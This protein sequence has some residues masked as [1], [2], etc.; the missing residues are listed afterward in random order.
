M[1]RSAIGASRNVGHNAVRHQIPGE[2]PAA[3]RRRL[4]EDASLDCVNLAVL[5]LD[6][7]RGDKV[8]RFDVGEA[9]LDKGDDVDIRRERNRQRLAV[10]GFDR[11]IVAVEVLDGAAD[12]GR[13]S[14]RRAGSGR[15]P[16]PQ[17]ARPWRQQ[18]AIVGASV[19]SSLFKPKMVSLLG[20]GHFSVP[21]CTH[22][23]RRAVRQSRIL[24]PPGA[25]DQV[26]SVRDFAISVE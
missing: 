8:A 4:G 18:R 20:Q 14:V 6:P 1:P 7:G 24:R 2:L 12:A 9:F 23:E 17:S 25:K 21:A 11:Q 10:A 19:K 22:G 26:T 16:A 13:R 3:I 15:V 5:I